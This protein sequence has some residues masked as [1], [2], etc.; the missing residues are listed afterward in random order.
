MRR[1]DEH[2]SPD[3]IDVAISQPGSPG[4]AVGAHLEGCEQCRR[5]VAAHREAQER[6]N[7]VRGGM[8][9]PDPGACPTPD[10]WVEFAM[11]RL[12]T[13]NV[14]EMIA[15]ASQCDSCGQILC[16]LTPNEDTLA[17][18][19]WTVEKRREVAQRIVAEQSIPAVVGPHLLIS[20]SQPMG[21][22]RVWLAT[23]AALVICAAVLGLGRKQGWFQQIGRA[24]V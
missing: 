23:A 5:T 17:P 16:E 12:D 1:L 18:P 24:H 10:Q 21:R 20:H 14:N 9:A 8:T 7:M 6:L 2:L 15:H 11:R 22:W 4:S 19:E 13:Q 3:E